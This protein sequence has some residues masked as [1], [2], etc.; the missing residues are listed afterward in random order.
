MCFT[1]KDGTSAKTSSVDSRWKLAIMHICKPKN[2]T[3]QLQKLTEFQ[4]LIS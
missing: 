3:K 4:A 1:F 2:E